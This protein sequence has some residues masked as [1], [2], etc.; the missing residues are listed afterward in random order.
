[1]ET[2]NKTTQV[3]SAQVGEFLVTQNN[4]LAINRD[5]IAEVQ[6]KLSHP[7]LISNVIELRSKLNDLCRSNE[8]IQN[9]IELILMGYGY[10]TGC[11]FLVSFFDDCGT[12]KSIKVTTHNGDEVEVDI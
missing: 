10:A 3:M 11:Q 1:M 9:Q 7:T 4:Y 12:I 8:E 6:E 5:R 2:T